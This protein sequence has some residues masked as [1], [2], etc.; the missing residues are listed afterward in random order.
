MMNKIYQGKQIGSTIISEV[1]DFLKQMKKEYVRLAIDDGNP[2][3]MHFWKKN[4]FIIIYE[5]N[6]DNYKKYVAEKKII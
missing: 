3:S 2:Q 6:I 4:G 1:I 5:K